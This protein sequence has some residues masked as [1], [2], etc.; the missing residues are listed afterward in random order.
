M[1][2]LPVPVKRKLTNLSIEVLNLDIIYNPNNFKHSH[3]LLNYTV[4]WWRLEN[5]NRWLNTKLPHLDATKEDIINAL[6]E[7]LFKNSEYIAEIEN[8]LVKIG[9]ISIPK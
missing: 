4:S 1:K 7:E 5:T 9:D 6:T 2:E 8:R 3:I